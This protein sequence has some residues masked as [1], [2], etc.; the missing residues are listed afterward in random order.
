[1]LSKKPEDRPDASSL[2]DAL[3][4]LAQPAEP[5]PAPPAGRQSNPTP[6]GQLALVTPIGVLLLI[7]LG[8]IVIEHFLPRP[9]KLPRHR[10]RRKPGLR[11]TCRQTGPLQSVPLP[12]RRAG[13]AKPHR[14]LLRNPSKAAPLLRLWQRA[15]DSYLAGLD[16]KPSNCVSSV[17]NCYWRTPSSI[18]TWCWWTGSST[19]CVSNGENTCGKSRENSLRRAGVTSWFRAR[20]WPTPCEC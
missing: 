17:P 6:A 16:Q 13:P 2:V 5:V 12:Q 9:S 18:P 1:M 10:H 14:I 11:K 3:H 7:G 4:A 15:P 19:S 8:I 20:Q